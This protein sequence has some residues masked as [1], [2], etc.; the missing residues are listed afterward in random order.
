MKPPTRREWISVLVGD[1]IPGYEIEEGAVLT[2]PKDYDQPFIWK[3]GDAYLGHIIHRKGD[4]E[5]LRFDSAEAA[6]VWFRH[7]LEEDLG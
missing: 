1:D 3:Q 7:R 2:A 6:L 4:A 5:N